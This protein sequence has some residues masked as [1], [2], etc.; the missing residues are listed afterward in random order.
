MRNLS[1]KEILRAGII[2]VALLWTVYLIASL[3]F[4]GE[5]AGQFGDAFGAL[6]TLFTGLAFAGLL[7]TVHHEN[8]QAVDR[9]REHRELLTAMTVQAVASEKAARVAAITARIAGYNQQIEAPGMPSHRSSM[10]E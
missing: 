8:Q 1:S 2:A 3:W 4:A 7:A 6:N 9:E 10:S 5:R